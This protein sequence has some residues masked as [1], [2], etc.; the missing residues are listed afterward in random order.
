VRGSLGSSKGNLS[1]LLLK[2]CALSMNRLTAHCIMM[3]H[4]PS[5]YVLTYVS[6]ACVTT[7]HFDHLRTVKTNLLFVTWKYARILH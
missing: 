2:P 4:P 3:Q 7:H 1:N 5:N 6:A